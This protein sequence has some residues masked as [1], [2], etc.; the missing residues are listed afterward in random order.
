MFTLHSQSDCVRIT[1]LTGITAANIS[2]STIHSLLSLLKENLM[3]A[4]LNLLQTSLTHVQLIVID[5][6]SF[7]SIPLFMT[8]DQQLQEIFPAKADKLF[9][10]MN[11][12]LCG[13]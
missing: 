8:L 3:G 4:R 2:G 13:D 9:A 5:E 7:L 12:L 1:A 11:I 10:G 6:Y